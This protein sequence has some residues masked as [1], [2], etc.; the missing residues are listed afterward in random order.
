MAQAI[1]NTLKPT[2]SLQGLLGLNPKPLA[3]NVFATSG[4]SATT[5]ATTAAQL[6][7]K[8]ATSI[9]NG[10][11]QVPTNSFSSLGTPSTTGLLSTPTANASTLYPPG[12]AGN[13]GAITQANDLPNLP[14]TP[15]TPSTGNFTTPSGAV[16]DS[17]GNT[18]STPQKGLFSSVLSSLAGSGT[19]NAALGA[20]A[21]KIASDAGT[22][23][24]NVGSQAQR[25][26]AGQMSTGT[27]PVAEGNAAITQQTSA[28]E[29]AAIAAGANVALTGNA[30]ALTGQAQTQ[31]ALTS[32]AGLAQPSTAA[33]G[34][35]VFDPV[36]G[37]YSGAENGGLPAD[38]MQQYAQMAASGQYASIPSSI[39]SNAVLNAQLNSAAKALNPAYTP[40]SAQG[41]SGVLAGIPAL[42]SASAAAEGIK[43]TIGTYLQQNPTINASQLAQGNVLSQWI[44]GQTSDPRY[45]ILLNQLTE[46]ANTLAPILGVGGDPT[47]MKTQIAQSFVNA[48]ANGQSINSVLD[49]MS[50]LAANKINDLQSGAI[51]GGTTVPAATG[52]G[53]GGLYDW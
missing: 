39:T 51:G 43:N 25:F 53:S 15:T 14:V 17:N 52:T 41:A 5:P 7:P 9:F 42:Q 27:T 47:N 22:Q 19:A 1:T 12:S 4:Q 20:N 50:S 31:S 30:Q 18:I 3:T 33:Y 6:T 48:A 28:A 23:I 26:I 32:A 2:N 16:V 49:A 24:S 44:A 34:N 45:S 21:Q 40:I 29:Q 13:G 11:T 38:V 46:Y 8:P 10:G 36:T 35:T 37:T